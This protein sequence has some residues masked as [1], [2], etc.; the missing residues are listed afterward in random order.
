MPGSDGETRDFSISKIKEF[1]A[2]NILDVGAGLGTYA[3][4]LK[5]ANWGGNIVGL[6]VWEPYIELYGLRSKYDDLIL[7]D[8]REHDDFNYDVVIFGDILEHMTKDEAV[9]IWKKTSEQ[10]RA[11]LIAIPIIHYPQGE[12]GGNP[13][14]EHV[15]DDWTVQEVLDTFHGIVDYQA[16]KIAGSFWAEFK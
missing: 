8:V 5:A 14:E 7:K 9:S 11:A 13:Y 15:K 1:G 4:E 16:G 3:I 6:E 12:W 10:A 2:E